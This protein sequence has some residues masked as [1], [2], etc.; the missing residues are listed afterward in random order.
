MSGL[1]I[2]QLLGIISANPHLGELRLKDITLEG[3]RE[4]SP[5]LPDVE[6]TVLEVIRIDRLGADHL[7]S[8]FAHLRAP[9]CRKFG[10]SLDPWTVSQTVLD[11]LISSLRHILEVLLG[12]RSAGS[13][14]MKLTPYGF[15]FRHGTDIALTLDR[16]SNQMSILTKFLETVGDLLTQIEL[17]LCH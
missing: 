5:P 3:Q 15:E 13:A 14:L 9:R 17:S 16:Y 12:N 6:A 10:L 1:S 8:L 7:S 2:S 11:R 4:D